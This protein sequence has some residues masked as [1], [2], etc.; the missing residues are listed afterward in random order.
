MKNKKEG[1]TLITSSV[2]I[3]AISVLVSTI[4]TFKKENLMS[5]KNILLVANSI[6]T[7]TNEV[8]LNE[9][10]DSSKSNTNNSVIISKE[11][12]NALINSI[13]EMK[14]EVNVLK[15][16]SNTQGTNLTTLENKTT[17]NEAK[18]SS[19]E[20]DIENITNNA[21]GSKKIDVIFNGNADTQGN[22]YSVGDISKYKYLV[23]YVDMIDGSNTRDCTLTKIISTSDIKYGSYAQY[24]TG[25]PWTSSTRFWIGYSFSKDNNDNYKLTIDAIYAGGSWKSPRI[26]KIEGIK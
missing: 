21:K 5:K 22:V 16:D 25:F 4:P 3:I 26:Y 18:I 17:S 10:A 19:I 7:S 24:V 12:G 13:N 2:L 15:S 9:S 23:I 8:A 20:T 11:Q 14:N 6:E 1:I